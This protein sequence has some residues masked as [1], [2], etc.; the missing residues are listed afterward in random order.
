MSTSTTR[1]A[2]ETHP[3]YVGYNVMPSSSP[4]I[5][6]KIT[7]ATPITSNRQALK[8]IC[9][10]NY[11]KTYQEQFSLAYQVLKNNY[12]YDMQH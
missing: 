6:I 10:N 5:N 2:Q 7:A 3:Q 8:R 9:K 11:R 12:L 4:A 1:H